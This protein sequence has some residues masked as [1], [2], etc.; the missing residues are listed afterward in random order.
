MN[1]KEWTFQYLHY[2][3]IGDRFTG[4]ALM[5]MC[6]TAINALHYP[7]TYLRYVREY[8]DHTGRDIRCISKPKSLYEVMI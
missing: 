4:Y 7:A 3:E 5:Q 2:L 1:A 6:N 8:R